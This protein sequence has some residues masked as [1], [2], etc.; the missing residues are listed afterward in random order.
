MALASPLLELGECVRERRTGVLTFQNEKQVRQFFFQ[1]GN[2]YFALSNVKSELPGSFLKEKGALTETQYA[3]YL[4]EIRKPKTNLWEACLRAGASADAMA[5]ARSGY[6]IHLGKTCAIGAP[7]ASKFQVLELEQ[8]QAHLHGLS[9]LIGALSSLPQD[10]LAPL[11]PDLVPDSAVKFDEKLEKAVSPLPLAPEEKGLV[12]VIKNNRTVADVF[13]SS[14]LGK[15]KIERLLVALWLFG[16]LKVENAKSVERKQHESS[17]SQGDAQFVA[18][19]RKKF[20]ESSKTTYYEWLAVTPDSK[21]EK[22]KAAAEQ[23]IE[24]LS[25]PQVE[26][27]FLKEDVKILSKLIAQIKEASQVLTN[28]AQ[29]AEYDTYI[30]SGKRGSFVQTSAVGRE[31]EVMHKVTASLSSGK[32]MEAF[33]AVQSSL[34]ALP[35]SPVLLTELARLTLKAF[36]NPTDEQKDKALSGLKKAMATTPLPATFEVLA[37]WMEKAGQKE[38]AVEAYKRAIALAPHSVSAQEGLNRLAPGQSMNNA[39][40]ALLKGVDRF[41]HY[42]LLGIP[43]SASVRE[44]QAA[45]RD[46]TKRFHPDLFF[47]AE[48]TIK[49]GANQIYK[50]MVRAYMTLKSADK[51]ADY[52]R[53]R[54]ERSHPGVHLSA[55]GAS[56]PAAEPDITAPEQLPTTAQGKK[57]YQLALADIKGGKKDSAIMNLKLALQLEPSS[58]AVQRRLSELKS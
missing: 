57:Y 7:G 21:S 9:F 22:I 35:D 49:N 43:D 48:P 47:N 8:P 40:L 29:R 55:L 36:P 14:F 41:S 6:A 19:L 46:C 1:N 2:P 15:E 51:R 32:P 24:K 30:A 18:L 52:D 39:V 28:V 33:T 25:S 54:H 53:K 27:M 5:Q 45:Y 38:K 26:K 56:S 50:Q 23:W 4:E 13:S 10:Q 42:E 12:T 34:A 31:Q 3:A 37:E 17:L 20:S 58:T 44:I 16:L 11:C